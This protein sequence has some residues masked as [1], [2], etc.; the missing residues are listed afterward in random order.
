[1]RS[2]GYMI[3][4]SRFRHSGAFKVYTES[5][6]LVPTKTLDQTIN[7]WFSFVSGSGLN[8]GQT[9]GVELKDSWRQVISDDLIVFR[10]NQVLH[11]KFDEKKLIQLEYGGK[12]YTLVKLDDLNGESIYSVA[13]IEDVK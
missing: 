13:E 9:G 2:K 3:D 11:E 4:A 8:Q 6:D 5:N 12:N 1:M 7:V 10:Y